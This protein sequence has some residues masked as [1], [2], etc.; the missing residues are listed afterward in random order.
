MHDA[1]VSTN[2]L[3]TC[4]LSLLQRLNYSLKLLKVGVA[5]AGCHDGG[6]VE[7]AKPPSTQLSSGSR[8]ARL[9]VLS[10]NLVLK[11][12]QPHLSTAQSA[13]LKTAV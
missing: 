3:I 10:A 8:H 6:W 5:V 1:V 13:C 9:T 11:P 12:I 7:K 4:P 2:S